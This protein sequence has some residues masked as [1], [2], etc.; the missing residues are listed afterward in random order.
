MFSCSPR[1]PH[2]GNH[3]DLAISFFPSR[4]AVKAA[5]KLVITTFDQNAVQDIRVK[6]CGLPCTTKTVS[7]LVETTLSRFSCS[8]PLCQLEFGTRPTIIP[9]PSCLY[10]SRKFKDAKVYI[11]YIV[12]KYG[13]CSK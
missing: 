9:S 12:Q 11:A 3:D 5:E 2:A 10:L 6:S 7:C 1:I 13:K 8:S 4:M